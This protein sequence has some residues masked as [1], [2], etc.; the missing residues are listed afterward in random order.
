LWTSCGW[1]R[2]VGTLQ[3]RKIEAWRGFPPDAYG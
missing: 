3:L 1:I 2:L